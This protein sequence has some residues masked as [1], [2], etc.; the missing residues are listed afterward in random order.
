[1]KFE[2][3]RGPKKERKMFCKL[4][5]LFFFAIFYYFFSLALQIW[6]LELEIMF[7]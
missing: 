1:M 3:R 6:F 5:N 2:S 4:E 7:P